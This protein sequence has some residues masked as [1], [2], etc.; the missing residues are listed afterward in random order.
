MA[1]SRGGSRVFV[2][3]ATWT[4]SRGDYGGPAPAMRPARMGWLP[5]KRAHLGVV[6]HP[7]IRHLPGQGA[8][9]VL[10]GGA[11]CVSEACLQ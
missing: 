3:G 6:S 2:T 8:M 9:T 1:V 5:M 7:P 11:G 4:A 10:V